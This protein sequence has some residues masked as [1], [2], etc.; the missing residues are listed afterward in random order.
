MDMAKRQATANE[1][2]VF[3]FL[4]LTQVS[5]LGFSTVDFYSTVVIGGE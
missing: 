1:S 3:V 2:T 4:S 5:S